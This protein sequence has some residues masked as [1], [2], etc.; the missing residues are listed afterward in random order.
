[1]RSRR[2]VIIILIIVAAAAGW[3]YYGQQAAANSGTLTLS[4]TIEATEVN[5]PSING[6]SVRGVYASGR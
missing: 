2:I 3:Y 5:L 6:G 4:G 1:M